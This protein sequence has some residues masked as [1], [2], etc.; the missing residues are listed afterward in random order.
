LPLKIKIVFGLCLVLAGVWLYRDYM[1]YSVMPV[2][3]PEQLKGH[4]LVT[5]VVCGLVVSLAW[6]TAFRRQN[7]ARWALAGLFVGGRMV[8]LVIAASRGVLLPYLKDMVAEL[9]VNPDWYAVLAAEIAVIVLMLGPWLEDW[10][11]KV[12][13]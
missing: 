9:P 10:F 4:F 7:W 8:P 11:K 12:R 5:A 6:M 13:A 3:M 2:P 1:L